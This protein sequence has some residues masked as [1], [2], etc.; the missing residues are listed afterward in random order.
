MPLI[1]KV[2]PTGTKGIVLLFE[3]DK[4]A[5]AFSWKRPIDIPIYMSARSDLVEFVKSRE[6]VDVLYFLL[7][8]AWRINVTL[9]VKIC[10][11]HFKHLVNLHTRGDTVSLDV[12]GIY[13]ETWSDK[14][15]DR[16]LVVFK[17]LW[18]WMGIDTYFNGNL[19]ILKHQLLE[20]QCCFFDL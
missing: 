20:K 3:A 13:D 19:R 11:R 14:P 18:T 12:I 2:V 1:M 8:E 9:E 15:R 17:D 16:S 5:N 7:K 10:L 4:M 6:A